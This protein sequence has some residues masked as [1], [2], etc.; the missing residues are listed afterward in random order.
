MTPGGYVKWYYITRDGFG[1]PGLDF[2]DSTGRVYAKKCGKCGH[3]KR[4][5]TKAG[6]WV[7]GKCGRAWDH[8]DRF[9]FKGE[10]QK[11]KT[12]DIFERQNAR[13]F[14]LGT[15]IFRMLDD[16][17]WE[18]DMKLYIATCLGHSVDPLTDADGVVRMP[19]L[20]AKFTE[21][22]PGAPGPWSR[23]SIYRRVTRA[24]DEW[25]RRLTRAGVPTS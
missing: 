1:A 18:W 11:P 7:C 8:E 22:W 15:I 3:A 24:K 16:D 19:G 12:F 14:D 13:W 23:A 5:P 21:L 17:E 2:V 9:I 20:A 6:G 10:V 4:H 25:V